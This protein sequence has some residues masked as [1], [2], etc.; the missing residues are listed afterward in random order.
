MFIYLKNI[1]WIH[2]YSGT[3]LARPPTGRHS[4]GRIAGLGWV[5]STSVRRGVATVPWPSP[6]TLKIKNV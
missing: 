5:A 6:Q 1:I 4:I 3:T 2:L